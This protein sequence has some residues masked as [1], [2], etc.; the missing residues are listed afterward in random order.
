M[1]KYRIK[2]IAKR[3]TEVDV[4]K[5]VLALLRILKEDQARTAPPVPREAGTPSGSAESA[6]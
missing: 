6:A 1:A 5:V 2:V 4:D 3:R